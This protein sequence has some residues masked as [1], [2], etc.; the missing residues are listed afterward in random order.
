MVKSLNDCKLLTWNSYL[1]DREFDDYSL[2]A[3]FIY[4]IG[5]KP[6]KSSKSNTANL[7]KELYRQQVSLRAIA[8]KE[9]YKDTK[10]AE[11]EKRRAK[12]EDQKTIEVA[13]YESRLGKLEDQME[14]LKVYVSW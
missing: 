9:N 11:H 6:S 12:L 13:E 14:E 2:K 4:K 5:Y 10:I 7:E 3:G 8:E 1:T